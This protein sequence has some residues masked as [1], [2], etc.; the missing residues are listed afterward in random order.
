MVLS[1]KFIKLPLHCTESVLAATFHIMSMFL[2]ML[3]CSD[4]MPLLDWIRHYVSRNSRHAAPAPGIYYNYMKLAL[5]TDPFQSLLI[6]P[7]LLLYFVIA[8]SYAPVFSNTDQSNE[9][10]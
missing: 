5:Y 10:N 4:F 3:S 1:I 9:W 7:L 8:W 6:L 2:C